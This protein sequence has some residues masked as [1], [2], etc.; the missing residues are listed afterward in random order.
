MGVERDYEGEGNNDEG[1]GDRKRD[2]WYEE[3]RRGKLVWEM[4]SGVNR[5][6]YER[7]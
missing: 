1:E 7:G 6:G 4:G 3:G 5:E 2:S